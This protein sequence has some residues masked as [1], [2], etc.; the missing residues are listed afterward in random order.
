MLNISVV[1]INP[2]VSAT[3]V[4]NALG[5]VAV[6]ELVQSPI[7]LVRISSA[8]SISH[9]PTNVTA[10]MPFLRLLRA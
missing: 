2:F 4:P 10:R 8:Q 3:H 6:Q 7:V 1:P 9:I 5:T